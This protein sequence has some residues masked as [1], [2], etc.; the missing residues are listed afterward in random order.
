MGALGT[1][2]RPSRSDFYALSRRASGGLGPHDLVAAGGRNLHR[3]ATLGP[4]PC[5]VP[6]RR[7]SWSRQ[8]PLQNVAAKR[9]VSGRGMTMCRAP[10]RAWRFPAIRAGS[11]TKRNVK[12]Q[13]RRYPRSGVGHSP[14]RAAALAGHHGRKHQPG[15]TYSETPEYP[16]IVP[17]WGQRWFVRRSRLPLRFS[18][19]P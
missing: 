12:K 4:R 2:S 5:R 18:R 7:A 6:R 19:T 15:L 8:A 10:V 3:L 13:V 11:V 14:I 17:E 9:S 16:P 1:G